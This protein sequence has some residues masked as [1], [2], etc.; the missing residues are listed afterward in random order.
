MVAA[1]A[2]GGL[3]DRVLTK[4]IEAR[5]RVAVLPC[6]HSFSKQDQGGLAGWLEPSLAIDVVRA[7]RLRD[8]GYDVHT[9]T[10]PDTIT[11]KNRLLFGRPR[12]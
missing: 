12:T 4:A 5:A 6:C 3:T 1:H 10:I 11:P 8:A 9:Q 7:A 2:C